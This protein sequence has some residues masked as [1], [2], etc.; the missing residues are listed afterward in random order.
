MIYS[1]SEQNSRFVTDQ[2]CPMNSVDGFLLN[3]VPC[4]SCQQLHDLFIEMESA[5]PTTYRFTCPHTRNVATWLCD[6]AAQ[7][8][9]EKPEGAIHAIRHDD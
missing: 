9:K 3:D 6:K 8:S 1:L 5:A 7:I 2:E 4:P